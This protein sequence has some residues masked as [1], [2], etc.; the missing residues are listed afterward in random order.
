MTEQNLQE[1]C[2]ALKNRISRM[3]PR[4]V[5]YKLPVSLHK[6]VKSGDK[7]GFCDFPEDSVVTLNLEQKHTKHFLG[8][9]GKGVTVDM[10]L[11]DAVWFRDNYSIL[12]S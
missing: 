3:G 12:G 11:E 6:T 9:Y 2:H 4:S 7:N 8:S 5:F 1:Y 10:L